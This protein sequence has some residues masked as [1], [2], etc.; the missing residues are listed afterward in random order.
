MQKVR[1]IELPPM[2]AVYSGPLKDAKTFER[3]LKWFSGFHAGLKN[4]LYPR[5]FMRYNE[6]EGAREW[7]RP[8]GGLLSLKGLR[9]KTRAV[10]R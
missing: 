2:K 10:L 4:E 9:A 3:Y 7:F 5:D 1:I 8:P 6:R